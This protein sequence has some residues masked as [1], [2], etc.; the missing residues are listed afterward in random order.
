MPAAKGVIVEPSKYTTYKTA[1][2]AIAQN[3]IWRSR[4]TRP[5]SWDSAGPV[6][7]LQQVPFTT[8]RVQEHRD[9]TV[10]LASRRFKE[11]YAARAHRLV[12]AP[13]V[14]GVNEKADPSPGLIAKTD[15]LSVI[16]RNRKHQRRTRAPRG[17]D[18]DP[19]F[20]G[21]EGRVFKNH[22][23]EDVAKEAEAVVIVGD[24]N[25]HRG[26]RLDHGGALTGSYGRATGRCRR[27]R[28]Q[29]WS[30]RLP[31]QGSSGGVEDRGRRR[32]PP[33]QS[34]PVRSVRPY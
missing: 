25:G 17:C 31:T 29:A 18:H 20:L 11:P 4:L 24:K 21:P 12:V 16:A 7:R 1:A 27:R 2:T 33:A 10:R 3:R 9:Q 6:S 28:R 8:P 5:A 14:V 13:E 32:E 22:E 30:Q 23:A 19:A 15:A 34:P 26:D